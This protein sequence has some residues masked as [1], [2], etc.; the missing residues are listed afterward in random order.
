M[1]K[2]KIFLKMVA[3]AVVGAVMSG[4]AE[5]IEVL[6]PAN[7]RVVQ[8]T[9]ISL[10]DDAT[11]R[12]AIAAD[13]STSFLVDDQIAVIYQNTNGKTVK[14]ESAKLTSADLTDGG[15]SATFTVELVSP[16]AGTKVRYIYPASMAAATIAEDTAPDNDLTISTAGLATQDGTLETIASDLGLAVYDGTMSTTA[17]LPTG[18]GVELKN[19]LAILKLQSIKDDGDTEIRSQITDLTV[20]VGTNTYTIT[21]TAADAPIYVAM[22][23]VA[24]AEDIT[25]STTFGG[26]PYTKTATG[27]TLAKNKIYPVNLAM[28][29]DAKST[30][31]TLE[32]T[33]DNTTIDCINNSRVPFRYTVNGVE[34][35]V[36]GSSPETLI[37]SLQTGDI[38]QF[39]STNVSLSN[40]T[41]YG[42]NIRPNKKCYV[43]G[44]VMSLIV[45]GT[46]GFA[47]DKT[48]GGVLSLS[49]LFNDAN[50]AFHPS[51][52]LVLPATTLASDCYYR[53]FAECDGITSLPEDFLP[54]TTLASACYADM[55]RD[56]DGLTS[57]PESLLPAGKEGEGML[58]EWCYAEMFAGCN[59]LTTLPEKLLPAM[60]LKDNCYSEMFR[61]CDGL[62]TLPEKLLPATT[63][64]ESCYYD[65]FGT[66][67]LLTES[68]VLPDA[69]LADGCYGHMFYECPKL[70]RVTCLVKS[71]SIGSATNPFQ[72]WLN[73]AGTDDG[74]ER[75]V[76]VDPTMLNPATDIWDLD[77]SGT[78]GKRWTATT[79]DY[80]HLTTANIGHVLAA[81]GNIYTNAAS[82][83]TAGTTARAMIAYVGSVPNYFD[84]FLAIA[85]D[86]VDGNTHT[87]ADA[88]TKV[89]EYAGT[90]GITIGGTNHNTNAIGATYYDQV[91][92]NEATT[93]ATRTAGVVKGW[94]LPSVTD[95]RYIF[96]GIGRIKNGV[97]LTAKHSSGTPV[98]SSNA[99]PTDPL[100][101]VDN[102]YYYKDNDV[103]GYSTLLAKINEACGNSALKS[104]LYW[105]SSEYSDNSF[106]AWW[107][108]FNLGTFGWRDKTVYDYVRAVFAY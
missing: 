38:V 108:S 89:G 51:K 61:N 19:Q 85:I 48:I 4:C 68:P 47:N 36:D 83:T 24:T 84:H 9:T 79:N 64:A 63:L 86:D 82:A 94:R 78:D 44:N 20:I 53:M 30:P 40:G 67:D 43:Y 23:P 88:H 8:K 60:T 14:A 55:F 22:L 13:G 54:A 35:S 37:S 12:G 39:F 16:K 31:L 65:M 2:T 71:T 75:I 105:S 59:G 77:N 56:C 3:L 93:S 10:A 57:L 69:T 15:A 92:S 5:E 27:K 103:A 73:K 99:T 87:W 62:T 34:T 104:S 100:G 90:H 74:C 50:I 29:F 97:T 95:W 25:I 102:M 101:V 58:A 66:C 45:D 32:V 70:S 91:A 46:E 28:D 98:Y 7:Q 106:K 17:T 107:Y 21:R 80:A 49:Y 26:F 81:D 1:K 11:T 6:Q 96:D 42:L 33:V 52:R 76:Y 72:Y 41:D 18:T